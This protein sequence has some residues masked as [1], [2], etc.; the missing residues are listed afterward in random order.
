MESVRRSG[1]MAA[2]TALSKGGASSSS[3]RCPQLAIRVP[4]EVVE[5]YFSF[6]PPLDLISCS[7]V[8]DAWWSVIIGNRFLMN[9]L[10]CYDNTND[11]PGAFDEENP[12]QM[13]F[14]LFKNW[15]Y[16]KRLMLYYNCSA[17]AKFSSVTGVIQPSFKSAELTT[18][19][20]ALKFF[21]INTRLYSI[22]ISKRKDK[23]KMVSLGNRRG[24]QAEETETTVVE[25]SFA[26]SCSGCATALIRDQIPLG[27]L[28]GFVY[29]YI[30]RGHVGV[31][32]T[33]VSF[34]SDMSQYVRT[35]LTV[36]TLSVDR[37]LGVGIK[38]LQVNGL[39]VLHNFIFFEV[40]CFN[41][42]ESRAVSYS[43]V[44]KIKEVAAVPKLD[45]VGSFQT[46]QYNLN[47]MYH[48]FDRK[49]FVLKCSH[50]KSTETV[51][52]SLT[53]VHNEFKSYHIL[54][55]YTRELKYY[56]F[57]TNYLLFVEE[58][59]KRIYCCHVEEL[60]TRVTKLNE[61]VENQN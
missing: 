40:N 5:A 23:L 58:S 56:A 29:V 44:L 54:D 18:E 46:G 49:L 34:D 30:M 22:L 27:M 31:Q 9:K 33:L 52:H 19:W 36:S 6:L 16:Y 4:L 53:S 61:T 60:Q 20:T 7:L 24:G 43:M 35:D 12:R 47:A 14:R 55:T 11:Y 32:V 37:D 8:C 45:L 17:F 41:L 50:L 15:D 13:K 25:L 21:L 1:G 28:K 10:L 39:A 38:F 3:S 42:S 26:E 57:W 59:R 2:V 51:Y 48:S